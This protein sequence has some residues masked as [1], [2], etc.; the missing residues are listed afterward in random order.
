MLPT[1]AETLMPWNL[2]LETHTDTYKQDK[3]MWLLVLNC[4]LANHSLLVYH[5]PANSRQYAGQVQSF[6]EPRG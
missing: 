4:T 2:A 3:E 6:L 5:D 1:S